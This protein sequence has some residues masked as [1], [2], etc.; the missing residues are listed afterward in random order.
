MNENVRDP[1]IL[2]AHRVES[3]PHDFLLN[4]SSEEITIKKQSTKFREGCKSFFFV[5]LKGGGDNL[6]KC[7]LS[8]KKKRE[9]TNRFLLLEID[10][11]LKHALIG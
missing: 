11:L 7:F 6:I 9:T 10:I 5:R 4:R 1:V 3:N 2:N 8:K